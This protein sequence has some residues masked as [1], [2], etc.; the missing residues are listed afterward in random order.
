[1]HARKGEGKGWWAQM[2]IN[3]EFGNKIECCPEGIRGLSRLWGKM[4]TNKNFT[5]N[6]CI[7]LGFCLLLFFFFFLA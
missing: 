3:Q 6:L 7:G 4:R 2:R 1:M 5:K